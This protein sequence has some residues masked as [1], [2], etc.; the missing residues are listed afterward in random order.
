MNYIVYMNLKAWLCDSARAGCLRFTE[1]EHISPVP[2]MDCL[3]GCRGAGRS[4]ALDS[5]LGIAK[6]SRKVQKPPRHGGTF[7]GDSKASQKNYAQE[8]R[9]NALSPKSDM[10][11]TP[12]MVCPGAKF[13]F[14]FG[15][16]NLENMLS[17][18]K[19]W[20]C[21]WHVIDITISKGRN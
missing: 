19:I 17:A 13:I 7:L 8:S 2:D 12:G 10:S 6:G 3:R 9:R 20:C 4:R 14:I 11:E 16:V 5:E 1:V 15:S 18:S 21:D